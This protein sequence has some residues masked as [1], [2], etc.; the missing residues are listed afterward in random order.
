M[1]SVII[2]L[3]KTPLSKIK[4][5]R[6]YKNLNLCIFEQQGSEDRK[7]IIY[8]ELKFKFNYFYSKKNI[9][10]PKAVNYLID[11]VDTKYCLM[12]EPDININFENI[13]KLEKIIKKNKNFIVVGPKYTAKRNLI[14]K[15]EEKI[16]YKIRKFIDPSCI[17]FNVRLIKKIK[18]YDEDYYFY[19]EDIDL[20][21]RINKTKYKIIELQNIF[22]HHEQ[23]TSSINSLQVK[24]V[25]SANFKY[26][27]FLF[28][29]K[30]KNVRIIKLIRQF[31]QNFFF[32]L[33]HTF[34]MSKK[35]L[36][37][38]GYIIGIFKF[39]SYLIRIR[40]KIRRDGRV[41]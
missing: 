31:F 1:L 2:V 30:H 33:L 15:K 7:K 11:K 22:A 39:I 9:G 12:S 8:K 3:Y 32:C 24:L 26:G 25:K 37:S 21:R 35:F 38:L 10:L 14:N 13:H 17:L 29:Y 16:N 20:M 4:N 27:E 18:F 28:D 40:L 19:W 23:S 36:T 6:N 41:V 5:L 34:T